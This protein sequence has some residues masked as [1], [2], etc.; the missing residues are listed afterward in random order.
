MV[1]EDDDTSIFS[2]ALASKLGELLNTTP[3]PRLTGPEQRNLKAIIECVDE[4]NQQ[5]RSMDENAARFVLFFKLYSIMSFVKRATTGLSW[6]EINWGFHS[7]SQEILVGQVSRFYNNRVL[8]KDAKASG[9][10]MW[11]KDTEAIV[12]ITPHFVEQIANECSGNKWR[13]LQGI[14]IP[15]KNRKILSIAPCTTLH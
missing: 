7:E 6:R 1:Q 4:V 3:I 14:I 10:F 2:S 12:S 11:L 13:S 9:M 5:R 8:W 15:R